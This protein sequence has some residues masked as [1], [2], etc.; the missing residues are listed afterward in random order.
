MW[1]QN[2][3]YFTIGT[4]STCRPMVEKTMVEFSVASNIFSDLFWLCGL[5]TGQMLNSSI[6][7]THQTRNLAV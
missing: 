5:S 2:S 7:N 4:T 3:N 6:Q 1:K